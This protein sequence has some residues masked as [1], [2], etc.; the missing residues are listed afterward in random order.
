MAS[1]DEWAVFLGYMADLPDFNGGRG[2]VLL[3][4]I[5][6]ILPSPYPV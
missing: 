5:G 6:Q 2:E 4:Y 3:P 1:R